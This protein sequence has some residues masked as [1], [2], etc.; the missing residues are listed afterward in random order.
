MTVPSQQ[1]EVT[2]AVIGQTGAGKSQFLNGYL[3]KASFKAC[4]DPHAV[5]LVTS[6][7]ENKVNGCLRRGIDTQGLDDTQ[8]V[9]AAHV[10]QM[11]T[12]LKGWVHGVNAFALVINGQHDRFDAGTQ[13]LVKLIHTFFNDATFWNH[14]CIIFTK[15]YAGCEEIDKPVKQQKYRR[16]LLNLVRE[17]QGEQIRNPPPLPVFFVDSKKY[18]TD[19]E[20]R[21]QYALLH[22]FVCGLPALR[23]TKI[24]VPNVTYLKV[25]KQTR[26]HIL[27]KV[28][29][30]GNTRIQTYEDQERDKR[31]GYD[32]H[33]ITFSEWKAIRTWQNR[34]SRS[35][36]TETET[37]CVSEHR[38]PIFRT[39]KY[40]SRRYG[41]CG[42][43]STR[44]VKCG[45]TVTRNM[46]ER[47]RNIY[48]DFDGNISYG[49]WKVIRQWTN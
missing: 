4:A 28:E 10:Q 35:S 2:L 40:G 42:P 48:R 31:T 47:S 45:E 14:V 27:A 26:R 9:D 49:D 3:Q 7:S 43:R 37:N 13:K 20:T 23:T 21:E 36:R 46:E 38:E 30:Q 32:G 22:G 8:G 5:T 6:S 39:E 11:V 16:L 18:D 12:F 1:L 19:Q 24:V 41:F 44:Q 15:C 25:E 33:T 34:Q 29:I 17:C